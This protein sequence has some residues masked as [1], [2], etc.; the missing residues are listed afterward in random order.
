MKKV[1]TLA[2]VLASFLSY[3]QT[4]FPVRTYGNRANR[5]IFDSTL[6]IPYGATPKTNM[7][8][9]IPG[10]LFWNTTDS[11]LYVWSGTA[12]IKN[13]GSGGTVQ[14]GITADTTITATSNQ[15]VFP[16]ASV[17]ANKNDYI[18]YRNYMALSYG[19]DYTAPGGVLTL[20]FPLA[21]GDIIRYHRTK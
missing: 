14:I 3:S 21:A 18:I 8:T 7:V 20:T 11:S 16:F 10:L 9:T 6:G 5:T 1:L 17:P 12:F 13:T 15:T 19:T 4:L 2:L